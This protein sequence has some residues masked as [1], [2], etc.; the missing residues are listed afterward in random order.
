MPLLDLRSEK[1]YITLDEVSKMSAAAVRKK[2][3]REER[4]QDAR[5]KNKDFKVKL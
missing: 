4:R 3:V 2:I 5:R 1:T